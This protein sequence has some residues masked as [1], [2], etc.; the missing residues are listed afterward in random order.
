M[1]DIKCKKSKAK[2][3]TVNGDMEPP[4]LTSTEMTDGLNKDLDDRLG[5]EKTISVTWTKFV[6]N[7]DKDSRALNVIKCAWSR[8]Q[9]MRKML[10]SF[11]G[12]LEQMRDPPRQTGQ[13]EQRSA[14]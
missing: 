5:L 12:E 1:I 2:P 10:R 7:T 6:I 11:W 8:T 3:T 9:H 13:T 14:D 4:E